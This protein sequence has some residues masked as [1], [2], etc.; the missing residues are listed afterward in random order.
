MEEQQTLRAIEEQN[1]E[2][3]KQVAH[4][5]AE[6]IVQAQ[7]LRAQNTLRLER[8]AEAA[9]LQQER[10]NAEHE[11][12]E[13]AKQQLLQEQERLQQVANLK[14]ELSQTVAEQ[15]AHANVLELEN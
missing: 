6:Q 14:Q 7:E 15:H 2:I 11:A 3:E 10:I 8:E 12:A 1:T 9:R 5:L 4:L 13:Q